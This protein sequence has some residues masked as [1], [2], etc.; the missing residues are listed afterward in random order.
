MAQ[1]I[2]TDEVLEQKGKL[3]NEILQ[4]CKANDVPT[5]GDLFLGLAFRTNSELKG[6]CAKLYIKTSKI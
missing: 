3:M 2:L 1:E 6:I 4:V 5:T